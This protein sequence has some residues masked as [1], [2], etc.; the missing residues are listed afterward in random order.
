MDHR[1]Y[2]RAYQLLGLESGCT[3]PEVKQAYRRRAQ[4]EHPDK[5]GSP[6]DN[7]FV[8]ITKAYQLLKDYR[9]R[10]GNL[11]EPPPKPKPKPQPTRRQPRSSS[12]PKPAD[13]GKIR[14]TVWWFLLALL[15]AIWLLGDGDPPQ[16]PTEDASGTSGPVLSADSE[17]AAVSRGMPLG[18]VA[19]LLGPPKEVNGDIWIYPSSSIIFENGRVVDVVT[20][21]KF[22]FAPPPSFDERPA[23]GADQPVTLAIGQTM[24]TVL[25]I[26]GKP[27]SQNSSQWSYGIS[28]IYFEEGRVTGWFNSPLDPLKVPD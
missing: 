13:S 25:A 3:W 15:P 23:T 1:L 6:D 18:E 17:A 22:E 12:A 20:D 8:E 26:Q 2:N 24:E 11:P 21:G 27:L 28:K 10:H 14:R 7:Q 19:D 5:G 9:S 16:R 4:A